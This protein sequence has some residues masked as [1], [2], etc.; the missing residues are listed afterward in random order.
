LRFN[1]DIRLQ[2]GPNKIA[3]IAEGIIY[4]A[5]YTNR[6]SGYPQKLSSIHDEV[7]FV[8][9]ACVKVFPAAI[10]FR[11]LKS[12]N[13]ITDK[14]PKFNGSKP[15]NMAKGYEGASSPVSAFIATVS[16]GSVAALLLR[17]FMMAGLYQYGKVMLAFTVIAMLSMLMGN[18][19]ALKQNNL[20]RILAYSSIAHLGYL[21]VAFIAGK[22]MGPQAA[23]FYI[24]IY[25]ITILGAFGIITLISRSDNEAADIENYKGLFW[26]KPLLAALFTVFLLSLAGIPLTAGFI[27]KYF[28]LTA[29]LGKAQWMLSFVLVIS[30]VIGLF[31]YLR[32][33]V[34][35]MKQDEDIIPITS[36]SPDSSIRGI[37]VVAVLGLVIISLGVAPSWLI[38]VINSIL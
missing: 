6:S 8:K 33:I 11:H 27:G 31:Y 16:K 1:F 38:N 29:G 5:S 10:R 9:M 35:M 3:F 30:S 23:T 34:M 18:L 4:Y 19:L 20:K 37:L 24:T 28:L 36:L 12:S 25:M 32:L 26:R 13:H 2:I 21:L 7:G 15:K 22:G 17:F 14:M